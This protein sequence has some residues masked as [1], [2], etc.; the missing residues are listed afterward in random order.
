[1]QLTD[2][3]ANS[4]GIPFSVHANHAPVLTMPATVIAANAGQM[5]QVSSWFSATDA[6]NDALTY[7]F[8]DGTTA[9]NSGQFVL[10]GTPL[11]Q[12]A[13]FAVNAA[14]L[15]G[16]TFVAGADGVPDSLSMQLT[17][18][19]AN[20]EGI[21]FSVH[22]NDTPEL[23][24]PAATVTAAAGQSLSM[25]SLFG[26]TDNDNDARSGFAFAS[27]LGSNVAMEIISHLE[28]AVPHLHVDIAAAGPGAP[29]TTN[30]AIHVDLLLL[31]HEVQP[32]GH[33]PDYFMV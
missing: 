21:P 19:H 24:A 33:L 8:A 22:V 2:G 10:N 5:L 28:A 17:D 31:P 25:A 23:T 27:T 14:Q 32:A 6:D 26:A 18:G 3:H 13:I 4:E 29:E 7:V 30:P 9:A 15:A 12:G 11:G 1:M 20:S 16:L